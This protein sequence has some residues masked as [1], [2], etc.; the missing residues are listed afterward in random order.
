M[1][2]RNPSEI[3]CC[4]CENVV[5]EANSL[6]K[7][8]QTITYNSHS[9]L[10]TS[11]MTHPSLVL[12]GASFFEPG[13]TAREAPTVKFYFKKIMSNYWRELLVLFRI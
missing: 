9:L 13:N 7:I 2:A 6:F 12:E 5:H 10:M 8:C 11:T 3:L 4:D 1:C